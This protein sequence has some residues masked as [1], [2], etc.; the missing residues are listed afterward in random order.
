[1]ILKPSSVRAARI[2]QSRSVTPA[3]HSVTSAVRAPFAV[4]SA[5]IGALFAVPPAVLGALFAVL[6]G[7]ADALFCMLPAMLGALLSVVPAVLADLLPV[8]PAVLGAALPVLPAVLGATFAAP[9]PVHDLLGRIGVVI[10]AN[11]RWTR[12]EQQ[13]RGEECD[14]ACDVHDRSPVLLRLRPLA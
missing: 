1:M 4:L 7:V 11:E 9:V 14:V 10:G 3:V 2:R 8:V 6:G 13:P 12:Q 5:V